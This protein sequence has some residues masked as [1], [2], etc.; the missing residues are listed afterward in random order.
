MIANLKKQQQQQQP[1][2]QVPNTPMYEDW[3]GL[4]TSQTAQTI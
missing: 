2:Q 1:L 3:G 4:N